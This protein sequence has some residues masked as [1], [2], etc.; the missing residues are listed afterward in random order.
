MANVLIRRY[1]A[2]GDEVSLLPALDEYHRQHPDDEITLYCR[3]PELY[4]NR[5]WIRPITSEAGG[6]IGRPTRLY[7]IKWDDHIPGGYSQSLIDLFA[8]QLSVELTDRVPH[9]DASPEGVECAL[10]AFPRGNR[11]RIVV[12]PGSGW[13]TRTYW[14]WREVAEQL[15]DEYQICSLG[16]SIYQGDTQLQGLDGVIDLV[17]KTT[18]SQAAGIIWTSD[19]F[20]GNCSGFGMIAEAMGIPSVIVHGPTF[21]ELRCINPDCE[22]PIGRDDLECRGCA[23]DPVQGK[24]IRETFGQCPVDDFRCMDIDPQIIVSKV[25]GVL[26]QSG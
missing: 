22:V 24:I 26:E 7:D 13:R 16:I 6:A 9:L 20:L 4:W 8:K 3:F 18:I 12:A 14:R 25:R 15:K 10:K 19:I 11:K 5:D 23:H 21:P 17:D 2:V 1:G